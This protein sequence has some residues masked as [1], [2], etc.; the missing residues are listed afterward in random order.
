[1]SNSLSPSSASSAAPE[2]LHSRRRPLNRLQNQDPQEQLPEQLVL[3]QDLHS[4]P[5]K[6]TTAQQRTSPLLP[7]H[8]YYQQQQQEQQPQQQ[9]Q[10]D[11]QEDLDEHNLAR[12]HKR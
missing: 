4:P 12:E 10:Q 2:H 3:P 6:D 9:Q 7:S 1:M 5:P 11:T 8:L